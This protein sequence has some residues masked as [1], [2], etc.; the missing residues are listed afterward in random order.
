MNILFI[1]QLFGC[2]SLWHHAVNYVHVRQKHNLIDKTTSRPDS[3][4]LRKDLINTY[5]KEFSSPII[6]SV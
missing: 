6:T 1:L 5:K 3:A 2:S 4:I